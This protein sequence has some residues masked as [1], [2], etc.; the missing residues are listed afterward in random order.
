MVHKSVKSEKVVP[1][2]LENRFLKNI[3]KDPD[4]NPNSGS[5][6]SRIRILYKTAPIQYLRN[7]N[8]GLDPGASNLIKKSSG[9]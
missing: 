8:T 5:F 2:N 7:R 6:K 9:L 4:P 3:H 1:T